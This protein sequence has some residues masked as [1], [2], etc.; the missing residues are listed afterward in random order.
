MPAQT[1]EYPCQVAKEPDTDTVTC[2]SPLPTYEV[3]L[4]AD[5]PLFYLTGL[6]D[7]MNLLI[8]PLNHFSF[9]YLWNKLQFLRTKLDSIFLK[10]SV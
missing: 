5:H 6:T 3:L 2:V 8:S 4:F 1:V 9:T 10:K 7:S